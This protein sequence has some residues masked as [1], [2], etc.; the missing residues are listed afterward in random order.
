ML[1]EGRP[2][3]KEFQHLHARSP[4]RAMVKFLC[5][6]S[7]NKTEPATAIKCLE[8]VAKKYSRPIPPL[9]WFFLIEYIN[10]GS[11]F[12]GCSAHDRFKM[13]KNALMIAG[14]QIAHSGSAKTLI[15]NYLQSF[16]A[17]SKELE[18]IQMALELVSNICD[19]VS[20]Q[21]LVTFIRDTLCFVHGLSASSKF[22]ENCQFEIALKTIVAGVFDR[23]CSVPENI[24]IIT[25]EI[26]KFNYIL[27]SDSKVHF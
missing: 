23:K 11:K 2:E 20:P 17:S 16:D 15:E 10:Q 13:K 26:S 25:D 18:E 14:N 9:N 8:C 3:P 19:G 27:S 21:I 4:L 1:A 22:E 24:D 7:N 6:Q 12:G 5:E